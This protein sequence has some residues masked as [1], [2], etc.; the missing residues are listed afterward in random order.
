M[1]TREMSEDPYFKLTTLTGK[2]NRLSAA[3]RRDRTGVC[4]C[5]CV[6]V[7][8]RERKIRSGKRNY[9]MGFYKLGIAIK[10]IYL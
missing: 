6:C 4:V 10:F 7:C 2:H 3:E 1:R 8:V 5:V 9:F